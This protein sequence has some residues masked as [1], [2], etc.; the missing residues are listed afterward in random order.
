MYG[1]IE[2]HRKLAGEMIQTKKSA[3]RAMAVRFN[4][5]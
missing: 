2:L 1:L 3:A 4:P 5:R